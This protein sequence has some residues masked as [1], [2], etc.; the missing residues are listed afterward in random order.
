MANN[1]PGLN[2]TTGLVFGLWLLSTTAAAV[3]TAAGF[4]WLGQLDGIPVASISLILL[5]I[6][7]GIIM[8]RYGQRPQWWKSFLLTALAWLIVIPLAVVIYFVAGA[9]SGLNPETDI[10]GQCLL[11]SVVVLG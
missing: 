6:P 3:S 5:G 1:G 4:Y 8:Q 7:Q 10:R 2:H 9:A 11:P